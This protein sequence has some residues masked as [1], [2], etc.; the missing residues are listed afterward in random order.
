MEVCRL[1][2]EAGGKG[3][4]KSSERMARFQ[5]DNAVA[6]HAQ[7][8]HPRGHPIS[9]ATKAALSD[10]L[11][12]GRTQGSGRERDHPFS[13]GPVPRTFMP[14]RSSQRLSDF[15]DKSVVARHRRKACRVAVECGCPCV[16]VPGGWREE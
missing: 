1:G 4:A 9:H 5:R 12:A 14:M 16:T 8:V 6:E 3:K 7:F 11:N 13:V 15:N 10:F 2:I